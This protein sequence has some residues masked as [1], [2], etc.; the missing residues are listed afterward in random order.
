MHFHMIFLPKSI[1]RTARP[2][3]HSPLPWRQY[4]LLLLWSFLPKSASL[5]SPL[6]LIRRFWGFRSRW[7]TFLLWQYDSPRKIWNKKTWKDMGKTLMLLICLTTCKVELRSWNYLVWCH[8][9]PDKTLHSLMS[10][11]HTENRDKGSQ[12][13]WENVFPH[14]GKIKLH[15]KRP[16]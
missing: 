11:E 4:Q 16:E 14:Q 9:G 3:L 6:S 8:F 10:I 1:A 5:S 13:W 7:R 15:R 12:G 2:L